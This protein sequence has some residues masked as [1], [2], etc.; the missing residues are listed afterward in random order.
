MID[1]NDLVAPKLVA[2]TEGQ[3][4]RYLVYG[5]V[6]PRTRLIRYVG[7]STTGLVRPRQHGQPAQLAKPSRKTSWV[8]AL[9]AAG[10][11]YE[12]VILET[13]SAR[14]SVVSGECFWIAYGRVCG[15]PL[16][17][18][19]GG[20]EGN[21]VRLHTPAARAKMAATLRGK[22]RSPA[23]VQASADGHRGKALTPAHR[24]KLSRIQQ[25]RPWEAKRVAALRGRICTPETRAKISAALRARRK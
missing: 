2:P 7:R 11:R 12:I 6:D 18:M 24:R 9:L 21:A 17:N 16:T 25:N 4:G 14:E 10:F 8:K 22:K 3:T 1:W 5:L 13:Y 23:A 15:W 19:S 20:G